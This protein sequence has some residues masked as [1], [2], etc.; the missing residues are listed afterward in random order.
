M[1]PAPPATQ[2]GW[3]VGEKK[4]GLHEH[5]PVEER[6]DAFGGHELTHCPPTDDEHSALR[7]CLPAVQAAIGFLHHSGWAE[8]LDAARILT[9]A[10]DLIDE[11]VEVAASYP[12]G[13]VLRAV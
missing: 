12:P 8:G 1:E 6:S 5:R 10:M 9:M 13:T 4:V 2:P 3:P 7:H 11:S